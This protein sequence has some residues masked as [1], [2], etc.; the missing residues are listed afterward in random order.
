MQKS[1]FLFIA[2][3]LDPEKYIEVFSWFLK[4]FFETKRHVDYFQMP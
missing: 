1:V 3:K 2:L 4:K